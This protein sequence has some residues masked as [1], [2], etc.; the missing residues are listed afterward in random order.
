M[1][2]RKAV[3]LNWDGFVAYTQFRRNAGSEK[4]LFSIENDLVDMKSESMSGQ[5]I[6]CA[7]NEQ[8][9]AYSDN[10]NALVGSLK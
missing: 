4:I 2:K 8:I 9:R 6:D 3:G 1:Q 7:Y 10:V 5:F